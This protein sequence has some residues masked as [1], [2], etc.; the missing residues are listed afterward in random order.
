M[1][2]ISCHITRTPNLHYLESRRGRYGAGKEGLRIRKIWTRLI[3][4]KPSPLL[5]QGRSRAR[6][7]VARPKA[8]Q[9]HKYTPWEP[10]ESWSIHPFITEPPTRGEAP[11]GSR[12]P[13]RVI[14]LP[15]R[16][17]RLDPSHHGWPCVV[18]PW[19][20]SGAMPWIHQGTCTFDGDINLIL[21]LPL[22]YFDACLLS[23]MCVASLLP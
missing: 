3:L 4:W 22:I 8:P 11:G 17:L 20:S 19:W 6:Q 15:R 9:G 21:S 5:S 23:F 12:R 1:E 7:G 13:P 18:K 10:K 16:W 2:K 14:K